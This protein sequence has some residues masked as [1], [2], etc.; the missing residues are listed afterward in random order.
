LHDQRSDT[1]L[2]ASVLSGDTAPFAIIVRRYERTIA[3]A[4][5]GML[6]HCV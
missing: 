2:I 6:G 5:T 3:A 1:E 4:F